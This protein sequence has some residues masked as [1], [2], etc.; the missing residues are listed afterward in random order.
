MTLTQG[1]ELIVE[2]E[3]SPGSA[4]VWDI[5]SG[6]RKILSEPVNKTLQ[7]GQVMIERYTFTALF[8]GSDQLRIEE[9]PQG[10]ASQGE[11]ARPRIFVLDITVTK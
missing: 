7:N 11:S 9:K 5:V 2:L 1:Q 3:R 8:V 4:Y 6:G 10:V